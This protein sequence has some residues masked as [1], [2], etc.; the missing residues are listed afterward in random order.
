MAHVNNTNLGEFSGVW[1]FCE[2]R[3]GKLQATVL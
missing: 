3:L 2:Q 1:V